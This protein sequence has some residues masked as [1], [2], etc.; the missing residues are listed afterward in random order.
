M[1]YRSF[2][3]EKL[4]ALG[5]GTMRLPTRGANNEIDVEATRS[6]VAYAM[7]KGINYFD[8]A[9]GYHGGSSEPVMGEILS[10]YPRESYYLASKFPGYD[11]ANM[12]K[13]EEIF[14]AQLRRCRT[15]YFDFYLFHCLCEMNVGPY[16]D[17]KN[18][19]VAYLVEQKKKGRIRH[20]GVSTHASPETTCRFLDAC[21]GHIEF[22][23]IQLNW[24]DWEFQQA[25]RVVSLLGERGIPVWVMEPLRGGSL[26]KLAPA[27]EERLRALAPA[28]SLP[29]W[30][31]RFL[32][33]IDGVTVVLS[34]MS[35]EEQLRENIAIFSEEKPLSDIERNT[36]LSIG[37]EMTHEKTLPCT[38]C[39]YC[40]DYCPQS[41][42]IPRLV[43][44]YNE[45]IY[46]GGG[47]MAPYTLRGFSKDKWP[48]ACIG[49][50]ACEG[51]CPQG[52]K[53]SEMMTD[54]TRRLEK[55]K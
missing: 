47:F 32:E 5:L 52:I 43:A 48:S 41:L 40:T 22:C 2:Q 19:I 42:D 18:G 14:E 54:F 1:I 36:L 55:K 20:L 23:Q 8:T 34:G 51:V 30:G 10:A 9:Y 37:Y 11:L 33:G 24:L 39:R 38:A 7:E 28:R 16:L 4:S 29:E 17:E 53:I 15:D 31:F 45:H 50:R 3:N 26:L 25:R 35:N 13:V 6:M 49:C 44:L 46:S 21:A 27:H 12:D